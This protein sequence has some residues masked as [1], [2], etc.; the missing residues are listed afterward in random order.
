MKK[1]NKIIYLTSTLILFV[2]SF[3]TLSGS[4]TTKEICIGIFYV[5]RRKASL[6]NVF[7]RGSIYFLH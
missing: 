2:N 5:V 1:S 6:Q 7:T 3:S 4:V